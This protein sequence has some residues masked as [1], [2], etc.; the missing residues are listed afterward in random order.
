MDNDLKHLLFSRLFD[1]K[2]GTP[3]PL[4]RFQSELAK[5]IVDV[6]EEYENAE[7]IRPYLNQVLKYDGNKG[8]PISDSLQSA[9]IKAAK[10]RIEKSSENYQNFEQEFEVA[11]QNQSNTEIRNFASD[12][13][14]FKI[15]EH[16][17][18]LSNRTVVFNREPIEVKFLESDKNVQL[19]A[20]KLIAI[21]VNNLLKNYKL[22]NSEAALKLEELFD[23]IKKR[24]RN[25]LV[26]VSTNRNEQFFYRYYV[27]TFN[28]VRRLYEGLFKYL[29]IVLL[30][31][32]EITQEDFNA[33]FS[34]LEL[35]NGSQE[36]LNIENFENNYE[37]A[38][39]KIYKTQGYLLSIPVAYYEN[40]TGIIDDRDKSIN[41]EML[42]SLIIE[43]NKVL[44]VSMIE[45]EDL[46]YWKEQVYY[47]LYW[48]NNSTFE[49]DEMSLDKIKSH[50][51]RTIKKDINE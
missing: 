45:N 22:S 21:V 23:L 11:Y 48:S 1:R 49:V 10:N 7:S 38:F 30:G 47:P 29:A 24:E 14:E 41:H 42:F 2:D 20:E 4:F 25:E 8:K 27:S 34:M 35:F 31:T 3:K 33:I 51:Q 13:K 28:T 36:Y 39:L 37:T 18:E 40:T 44:S 32:R 43:K 46:E 50:I 17:Q 5:E 19:D 9:I 26:L 6:S 12:E 15:L 16:W